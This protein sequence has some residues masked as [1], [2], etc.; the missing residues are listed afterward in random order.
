MM[1]KLASD[2]EYDMYM[3][4]LAFDIYKGNLIMLAYETTDYGDDAAKKGSAPSPANKNL[5][6]DQKIQAVLQV[7]F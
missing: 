4:G 3:G 2:T 6:D 5:G 1:I 7:K